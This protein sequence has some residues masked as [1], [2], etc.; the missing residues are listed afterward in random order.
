MRRESGTGAGA[1]L[2][3]CKNIPVAAGL[4]GGSV[5]AAAT[6]TGLNRFWGLHW[7]VERLE[8]L[9]EILGADV[10]A[11]VRNVPVYARGIGERLVNAPVLPDCGVL[12]VNPRVETPT[13]DVFKAFRASNPDISAKMFTPLPEQFPSISTLVDAI[14]PRG[15]DLLEA[16]CQVTPVIGDVLTALRG[17][18]GTA[19]TGLSGSGATCFALF[20]D[21]QAAAHAANTLTQ[22]QPGWWVWCGGWAS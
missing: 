8:R 1:R 6:L 10:P 15:N 11:C 22:A 5:D 9:S 3:L 21:A 19:H 18:S 12:L 17:L 7:P 13:P 16:A 4:G 20:R 2:A 14:A